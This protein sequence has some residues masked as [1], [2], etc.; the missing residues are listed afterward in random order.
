M[1]NIKTTLLLAFLLNGLITHA[2][3]QKSLRLGVAGLNH[4]H[5]YGILSRYR[6]GKANIVGIAEPNKALWVKFGKIFHIPDSLFFTDLKTMVLKKK[7]DAV[8]GYNA[9]ANHVDIVE[10][11]APLGIPV[12]VEKPM[13]AT[14]DQAKRI[15]DLVT[16]Y[17]TVFLVNYE[18]TWYQSTRDIYNTV[19]AGTIGSIKRM[20][21]HDGH[22]GPKE[23]GCSEEFLAWLTDPILNGAGALNDFGCYGADQMTWMMH[24]ERPIAVTAIARHYK[25]QVYPKVE[26]DATIIVEYK[27]ATGE[28]E[29]SWNWPFSIKDF[30]VFGETGYLHALDTSHI[31]SRM[32]EKIIGSKDVPSMEAPINDPIVYL[33][34]VLNKQISGTDDQS[35]L[36]YNMIVMEILD[37]AKRSIKEGKRI[38]L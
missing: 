20:V 38:V 22:Q 1:K 11:C 27:G 12:M 8:L 4:N 24:G 13:A 31:V 19:N 16:K 33:T 23:I 28:I 7:P 35:S 26:D 5:V 36:N 2:N 17:K 25:P 29:G 3:A 14:L 32:R 21:A 6:D 37:A 15:N 34:A 18:T 9:A 30:E 10:V